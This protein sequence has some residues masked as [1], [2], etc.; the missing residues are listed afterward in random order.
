MRR[1]PGVA[2]PSRYIWAIGAALVVATLLGC[3]V[4]IWDLRQEAIE[5]QR[6]A[7]GNLGVALAEQTTRYVQFV[8]LV[9][10]E[11]QSRVSAAHIQSPDE[12]E[13]SFGTHAMSDFLRDSL[14]GL[15]Q[16]NSFFL[17]RADGRAL[18]TS[19]AQMPDDPDYSNS[20]YYRHFL[21]LD[22]PNPFISGPMLNRAAGT[23]TVFLA[24]AIS[25]PGH[26]L[27]GVAVGAIDLDYLTN[28]YRAI[29]LPL[30]ESV[31]LLRRDGLILVRY[32]DQTGNAGERVAPSSQWS[33][34]AWGGSD[35]APG[36][37]GFGPEIVSVHPLRAWPL[38]IDVSISEPVALAR[39]QRQ[40]TIIA[41][42]GTA[43]S[44][45]FAVLFG[46]IGQ[47]FRRRAERT[48]QL[49][50]TAAA[51]GAREARVLD[52]VRM[53]TDCLWELDAELRFSWAS[54]SP[55]VH[56]M[57]IQE[58]MGM[59]PWEALNGDLAEAR[60]AR[61]RDDMVGHRPVRDFRDCETDGH[62]QLHH[63]SINGDPVFDAAG[64]FQGYRG[65]GRDITADVEAARELGL[66]KERA[67]AA[68][69][70]KSEFLANMS[71]ELRTPLNSIIGFSELIRDQPFA[72]IAASYVEYASE[73]N[74]AGHLLL[75]M[76]NDVLD[77]SKMEA[78]RYEL[79]DDIIELGMVVR[80][81]VSMLK[82]RASA[83]GV[84][85]DNKMSGMRIALRGDTRAVKQIVLN[86]LGNAIK[87]TPNG[88]SASLS[89]EQ[90]NDA[91][92]LV[93]SDT[94][95]G[96]EPSAMQS[97]G[98]PFKQ[99][100]SSI[101][102]RFGGSGLGLAI[103]RKLLAIHGGALFIDSTP[104]KGTT[105]RVSFPRERVVEATLKMRPAMPEAA[106]SA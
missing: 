88:G 36:L 84:R 47:Q 83:G 85:I 31:T 51:L 25:G 96:I 19:R 103:C 6:I 75:D 102:R 24:R 59:T 43:V 78:N 18:A 4:A 58:R 53:S 71:H 67:E 39:W 60:W 2:R 91:L 10:R 54:D 41:L 30:G 98:E 73:I 29:D 74:T 14:K 7:I 82:L 97:L 80:S 69:R 90:T 77:L 52:F 56:A 81:C 34:M 87:F 33:G 49:S 1:Q 20:D 37:L 63:V 93:V 5:R 68:N 57:G 61:L 40:A 27:L 9:L 104:G 50:E 79:A 45:G 70:T 62:G 65:T 86:L 100:D 12:F 22:D 15:P 92:V 105:V 21:E 89:V 26:S 32:P 11:I 46:V 95:I 64:V 13:L 55:M 16:A 94:G 76:I 106:L 44:C 3:G 28:F 35:R 23:P 66:A 99:A 17:L 38:V 48:L 8:D 101:S 42:G 72:K